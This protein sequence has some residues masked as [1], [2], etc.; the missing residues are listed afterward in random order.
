VF[1]MTKVAFAY[2]VRLIS[3]NKN[4]T[5]SYDLC[6]IFV[7]L[8][9]KTDRNTLLPE[10]TTT[11]TTTKSPYPSCLAHYWSIENESVND[12]VGGKHASS[13]SPQF[14]TDRNGMANGAI[15][16][17][18]SSS[19]WQLPE[20]NYFQ[21]DTTITMWVKKNA[22]LNQAYSNKIISVNLIKLNYTLHY[23]L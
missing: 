17:N 19:I 3:K 1:A 11:A 6:V 15:L 13:A 9:K 2:A 20:H 8:K 18:S 23:S 14:I 7:K 10:T 21:G 5:L 16:I 12:L 22:C 4:K